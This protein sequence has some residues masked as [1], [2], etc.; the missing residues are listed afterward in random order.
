M[1]IPIEAS[2]FVFTPS[3]LKEIDGAP[4]FTL[5]YGTR[6]DR[7]K[8][9]QELARRG[10]VSNSNDDLRAAILSEMR[11]LSQNSPEAIEK[12]VDAAE[13]FWSAGESLANA[14]GEW[15]KGCADLLEADPKATVPE[16][17][18][19][20]FDAEEEIWISNII[21]TVSAESELIGN[22][23]A[24]NTRRNFEMKEIA[25]AATLE[26]VEG[27]ELTR[28][29]DGIVEDSCLIELEEW[30]GSKSEELGVADIDSGNAY[31]ELMSTAESSFWVPKVTEKN[32]A[33]P[34]PTIS[35]P[36]NLTPLGEQTEDATSKVSAKSKGTQGDNSLTSTSESSTLP[37][38]A[39][40][41]GETLDGPI[42][43]D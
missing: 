7:H 22:M 28:R 42:V 29:H 23:R 41:D 16:Q 27:F 32:F 14:L 5:R 40:T 31:E 39:G 34:P 35:S 38:T 10:L 24:D 11:R 36:T 30:L 15:V 37:S 6:R 4:T 3:S 12:M 43:A 18:K 20:E 19:L 21:N 33:S 26:S 8:F 17:P 1:S 2:S 25:L 9:Q 13:R